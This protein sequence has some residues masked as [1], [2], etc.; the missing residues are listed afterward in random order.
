MLGVV[1]NAS[2]QIR[3]TVQVKAYT[4]NFLILDLSRVATPILKNLLHLQLENVASVIYIL[5]V[6]V[7]A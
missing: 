3:S 2:A 1:I 5:I 4:L 6:M 7:F